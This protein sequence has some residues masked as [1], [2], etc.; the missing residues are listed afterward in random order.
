MKREEIG[1]AEP[2]EYIGCGCFQ[3]VIEKIKP[4]YISCIIQADGEKQSFVS[5]SQYLHAF[6]GLDTVHSQI[7]AEELKTAVE[8]INYR[9]TETAERVLP[10]GKKLVMLD[11]VVSGKCQQEI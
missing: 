11:F 4:I 2:I 10:N 7:S 6:D 1:Y 3:R 8:E 5:D 9:L